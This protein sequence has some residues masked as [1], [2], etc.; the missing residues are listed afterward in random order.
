MIPR[1]LSVV[2]A[3]RRRLVATAV[4]ILL[5]LGLLSMHGLTLPVGCIGPQRAERVMAAMARPEIDHP[6]ATHQGTMG[7]H[8]SNQC[9][10][11]LASE[12]SPR[13]LPVTTLADASP[14][15]ANG[16][17]SVAFLRLRGRPP[18]RDR[19]SLVGVL[20]R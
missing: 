18:E 17:T 14:E 3:A 12:R 9:V 5:A 8:D 2:C 20:R 7:N 4:V 13:P 11:T 1:L 19:L 6:A 15:A 16:I 10:A